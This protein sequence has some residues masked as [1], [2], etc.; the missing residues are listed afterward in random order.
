MIKGLEKNEGGI[1]VM[2]RPGLTPKHET[3]TSVPSSTKLG[4]TRM[5][6]SIAF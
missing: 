2:V 5:A 4:P 3:V 1:P 6:F